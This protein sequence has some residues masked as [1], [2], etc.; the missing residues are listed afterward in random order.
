M[1]NSN[2]TK[3]VQKSDRQDLVKEIEML[4]D[5]NKKLRDK[6]RSA[7]H[8][9]RQKIDQLLVLIGTV[10]L[11]PEELED[12]MLISLD[13]IGIVSDSFGQVLEY[14]RH[15]NKELKIA[16]D[17][18]ETIFDSIAGG[19]L[20]LDN[21]SRVMA[22]NKN[23]KQM[24]AENQANISGKSCHEVLCNRMTRRE[25]C[26]IKKIYET[27]DVVKQ[28]GWTQLGRYYDVI[29]TPIK[30]DKGSI[31][32]VVMLYMDITDRITAKRALQESEELYRDLFENANDLI[33]MAGPDGKYQYVNRAWRKTLGY[34]QEEINH[35]SFYDVIPEENHDHCSQIHQ[36]VFEGK[37]FDHIRV[38]FKKKD[39]GT[40]LVEGSISCRFKDGQPVS[41]R[42]IFRDITKQQRME[43]ELQKAQKLESVGVL[44]GGIAHDFNNLLTAI[45]GNISLAKLD[46]GASK[47]LIT[48][49]SDAEKACLRSKDLT[50]QLLT[51]SKG[52]TPLRKTVSIID[53]LE[54]SGNFIL[55]GS[56][57]RCQFSFSDNLMPVKVDEGQISQV[58]QNLI[59]NAAEAMP[60]GG[61]INIR[62]KN[63]TLT[64]ED[65]SLLVP[66]SYI[67]IFVS[68]SGTGISKKHIDRI[69]DPYFS[70]KQQGSGLGLAVS[71]S[72]IKNHGGLLTVHSKLGQ[73]TTFTIYIPT[74]QDQVN[75]K[76]VEN[77]PGADSGKH[78]GKI[79]L[80]DDE[81][82]VCQVAK[83]M[84]TSI[85]YDVVIVHDGAEALKC[86]EDAANFRRPFDVVIMDLTIPGGMGG[87]EA[88]QELLHIDPKAR[89][90]VSSGYTNGPVMSHFRDYG[91]AGVIQKPYRLEELKDLLVSTISGR[92]AE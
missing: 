37:K 74:S 45:L 25:D 51:F 64:T 34:S 24:F 36:Q 78:Q 29:G 22:Y 7:V 16:R 81:K 56:N 62:V 38:P 91:F 15:T 42:G 69:F 54:E 13:P 70:T 85:G 8:Y 17:E 90:L 3:K 55:S 30:N 35:L 92:N 11:K 5:E 33:Q 80:M 65:S 26:I 66:G 2:K 41:T 27:E 87:R 43:K 79:L 77:N 39:G 53:L 59:I 21:Q 68:D 31:S 12:D 60:E 58:I 9:I 82:M 18:I 47:K 6:E 10:P 83:K 32:Q 76:N 28:N 40:A 73:G 49:L 63:V 23:L 72:I 19:I 75:D 50:L 52:G 61:I 4:R 57:V 14:H 89:V 88:V 44:A 84:L 86:Y 1:N 67:Q 48:M 71:Y 20:V 46:S